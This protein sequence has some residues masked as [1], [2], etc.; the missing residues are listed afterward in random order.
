MLRSVSALFDF[1]PSAIAFAPSASIA[2]PVIRG[3]VVKNEKGAFHL[4]LLLF[5]LSVVPR[6][7]LE[8]VA[9][10]FSDS[11]IAF[12]PS[13]PIL[14]PCHSKKKEKNDDGE[15]EVEV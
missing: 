12:A 9:F 15:E 13:D 5:P 14:F 4:L 1:K 11:P 10:V 2:L 7:S 6:T 3:E 8:S